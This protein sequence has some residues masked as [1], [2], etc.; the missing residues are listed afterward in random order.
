M[1]KQVFARGLCLSWIAIATQCSTIEARCVNI[2]EMLNKCNEVSW[3]VKANNT[4]FNSSEGSWIKE[5]MF[6]ESIREV[7]GK[8]IADCVTEK[9]EFASKTGV[10]TIT[11]ETTPNDINYSPENWNAVVLYNYLNIIK[12][13]FINGETRDQDKVF[14]ELFTKCYN[15]Y[16]INYEIVNLEACIEKAIN[17]IKEYDKELNIKEHV[18]KSMKMLDDILDN[19]ITI[20]KSPI[21]HD[22]INTIKKDW[23]I[24]RDVA[25]GIRLCIEYDKK[26]T[27]D[28]IL[29]YWVRIT[30]PIYDTIDGSKIKTNELYL[31]YAHDNYPHVDLG[32][33]NKYK[34]HIDSGWIGKE[35]F[36]FDDDE[37]FDNRKLI[38]RLDKVLLEN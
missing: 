34:L 12:S 25:P 2:S 11:F 15:Y 38:R 22:R 7:I 28:K 36:I 16:N 31:S 27:K 23:I 8:A 1:K 35:F 5:T 19:E 21:N 20:T 9:N 32:P 24:N 17:D 29:G 6:S 4:I 18:Y 26:G 33:K 14:N 3:R 13:D 37:F 30:P 10:D